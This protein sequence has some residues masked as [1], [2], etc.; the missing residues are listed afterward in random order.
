[1]AGTAHPTTAINH[2]DRV[3]ALI[4]KY[5]KEKSNMITALVQFKL[6]Q[7]MTTDKAREVFSGT[8]P[9]YREVDL[10]RENSAVNVA[11]I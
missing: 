2:Y 6:P 11:M 3:K 1:L 9:K 4:K 7:P 10:L 8:A 5:I